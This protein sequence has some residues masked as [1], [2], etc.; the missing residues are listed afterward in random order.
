MGFKLVPGEKR[1]KV[2]RLQQVVLCHVRPT[3]QE[4]HMGDT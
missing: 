2:F 1:G 4:I 3:M